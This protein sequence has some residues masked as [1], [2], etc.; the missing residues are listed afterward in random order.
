MFGCF[1]VHGRFVFQWW[2][3]SYCRFGRVIILTTRLSFC[4]LKPNGFYRRNQGQLVVTRRVGLPTSRGRIRGK[5]PEIH[6][7]L[8]VQRE[9]MM[10]PTHT[11][12]FYSFA[13]DRRELPSCEP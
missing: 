4:N 10:D 1:Q 9:K 5:Q 7:N 12:C 3:L 2:G 13:K 6:G 11:I 8:S